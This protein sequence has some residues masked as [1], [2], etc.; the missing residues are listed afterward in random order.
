MNACDG[1]LGCV[2]ADVEGS[3][4][5]FVGDLAVPPIEQ[6][7]HFDIISHVE[8]DGR[9]ARALHGV[10][11]SLHAINVIELQLQRHVRALGMIARVHVVR[12]HDD[13][14]RASQV[15]AAV[16]D[17]AAIDRVQNAIP[18]SKQ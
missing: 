4:T 15:D 10:D 3:S 16:L 14:Q 7:P 8:V 9:H 18:E 2:P 13:L 11:G 1:V 12:M 5:C 17:V 6:V